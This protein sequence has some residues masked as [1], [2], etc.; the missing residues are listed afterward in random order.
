MDRAL[1]ILD[2]CRPLLRTLGALRKGDRQRF[3][4]AT[5]VLIDLW[6]ALNNQP[7][8]W[9]CDA[10]RW[11]G[12]LP[13][14]GLPSPSAFSRRVRS[15]RVA[16]LRAQLQETLRAAD[17]VPTD[18]VAVLIVD[19]HAL[20]V[21]RHSR[22][23]DAQFGRGAGAMEKGYKLHTLIDNAG[24]V[25]SW[26]LTPMNADEARVCVRLLGGVPEGVNGYILGDGSYNDN[27][28]FAAAR[29][30]G[31]QL[32]SPRRR[33]GTGLGHRAHD[34][35]RLRCVHLLEEPVPGGGAF[36]RG[37]YAERLRIERQ[38]GHWASTTE[39]NPDLPSFVRGYRRVRRWVECKMI[40]VMIDHL[41]RRK[42]EALMAA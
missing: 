5:I 41:L 31:L 38:F 9:A 4:D 32:A 12:K 40:A 18:R 6:A 21:A 22:D 11:P 14:G 17:A 28:L 3:S 29:V 35:S 16:T 19:G 7:A 25:L 13:P 23:R 34:P 39:L 8:K 37:L 36:G 2:Q 33:P 20:Q 1:K 10:A 24:R 30:R 27:K 15:P 26:R 42:P